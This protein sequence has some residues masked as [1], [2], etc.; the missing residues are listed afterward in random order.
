MKKRVRLFKIVI[1]GDPR[2]GKTS[3]RARYLGHGFKGQYLQTLGADFASF[4]TTIDDTLLRWQIWDLAGHAK[5]S[6]VLKR[7]YFGSFGAVVAYDVTRPETLEN[8]I[9]WVHSVW[10]YSAIHQ[11]IPVVLLANKIDLEGQIEI[12]AEA[13]LEVA[14]KIAIERDGPVHFLETS[15]KTGHKVN[16]AFEEL[17]KLIIE[18]TGKI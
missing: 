17:G 11:K 6:D 18:F 7:Y 3:L 4:E 2:V 13:G 14:K 10:E 12:K 9:E 15:A 5:F 16:E 8:V 1:I